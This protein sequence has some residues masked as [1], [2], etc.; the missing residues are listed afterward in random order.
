MGEG[1]VLLQDEIGI[2]ISGEVGVGA[3]LGD[4]ETGCSREGGSEGEE[5]DEEEE[6]PAHHGGD[7]PSCFMKNAIHPRSWNRPIGLSS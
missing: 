7:M 5:E 1:S 4:P 2:C 3:E 6:G